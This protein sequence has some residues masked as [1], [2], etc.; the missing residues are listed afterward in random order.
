M[1]IYLSSILCCVVRLGMCSF[2]GVS[3]SVMAAGGGGCSRDV[4]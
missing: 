4:V 3:R 2:G 1:C